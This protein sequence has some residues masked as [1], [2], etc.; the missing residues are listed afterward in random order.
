MESGKWQATDLSF[1]LLTS[2]G[3]S[4]LHISCAYGH[5]GW[6]RHPGG[7]LIG[8]GTSPLITISVRLAVGS[9]TGTAAISASV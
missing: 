1:P 9:G 2:S 5:L 7:G 4:L 6:N 8:L 3:S